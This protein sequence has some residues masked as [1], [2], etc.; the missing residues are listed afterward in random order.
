MA[1]SRMKDFYDL[2]VL[3]RDFAFDGDLLA[4]AI[5]ATFERRGM[6][7]LTTPPVAFT[8]TFA[9]DPTKQMQWSGFVR[10]AGIRDAGSLPET[11]AT[12]VA[13][14][15]APLMAAAGSASGVGHWHLAARGV[16]PES[17]SQRR[18]IPC[19]RFVAETND[20]RRR[21]DDHRRHP[22]WHRSRRADAYRLRHQL[23]TFVVEAPGV[24][25]SN[26]VL[27][28]DQWSRGL[29]MQNVDFRGVIG[30][31]RRTV[32]VHENPS[33][34]ISADNQLTTETALGILPSAALTGSS[35]ADSSRL[36][37]QSQALLRHCELCWWPS[38]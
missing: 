26:H 22:A 6:P 5:R 19:R 9:E 21:S 38:P 20:K 12:V 34:T 14:A 1:N 4:H 2:A 13:F 23:A 33:W 16:R 18:L 11:V 32:S 27:L 10:K 30:S 25:P 17:P 8:A 36:G 31:R 29:A 28:T 7:L 37:M 3:A 35:R 24:E 15:Q